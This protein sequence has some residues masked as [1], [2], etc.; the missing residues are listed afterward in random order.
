MTSTRPSRRSDAE[1]ARE[2]L[3]GEYEIGAEIGRG[4]M[5]VVYRALGGTTRAPELSPTRPCLAVTGVAAAGPAIPWPRGRRHRG[6]RCPG[7]GL[8]TASYY[9]VH[10]ATM[11]RSRCVPIS[12]VALAPSLGKAVPFTILMD[13]PATQREG[14][15]LDVYYDVCGLAPGTAYTTKVSVSRNGFLNRL[16]GRAAG[17]VSAT[18]NESASTAAVR[19]HRTLDTGELPAGQYTVSITITDATD[20]LR[21][22]KVTVDIAR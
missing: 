3:S 18:Y 8:I 20:R 10:F 12:A 2:A 7:I 9:A 15:A 1:L 16:V 13:S 6:A 21:E 17:P 22:R 14:D 4:G 19:R 5:A 11:H